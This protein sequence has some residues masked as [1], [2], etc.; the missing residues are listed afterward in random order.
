MDSIPDS[1]RSPRGE[2]NNSLQYSC[3]E[4]PMFRGA[5]QVT[6]H[7]VAKSQI[8]LKWLRTH[9]HTHDVL[10]FLT[11][12]INKKLPRTLWLG[13]QNLLSNWQEPG[14]QPS[15]DL[16]TL[17]TLVHHK[18]MDLAHIGLFSCLMVLI[19]RKA[20]D[21]GMIPG[22]FG[23][24]QEKSLLESY[25]KSLTILINIFA[26]ISIFYQNHFQSSVGKSEKSIDSCL[27][28][29]SLCCSQDHLPKNK[30]FLLAYK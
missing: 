22:G 24:H 10:E 14:S 6:V 26:F 15:L 11:L 8:Q 28:S 17:K 27:L 1:G 9:A 21:F 30:L 13:L 20:I 3:L 7:G 18:R 19:L 4:N 25:Y 16:R 12:G 2:H 29:S 5:W 23:G